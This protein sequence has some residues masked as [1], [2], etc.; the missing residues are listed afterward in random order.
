M[1]PPGRESSLHFRKQKEEGFLTRNSLYEIPPKQKLIYVTSSVT[2]FQTVHLF[3]IIHMKILLGRRA[4]F[5]KAISAYFSLFLENKKMI[6]HYYFSE[7]IE[8][9]VQLKFIS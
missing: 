6:S 2:Q 5:L 1:R 8:F 9:L 7:F 3:I 4:I